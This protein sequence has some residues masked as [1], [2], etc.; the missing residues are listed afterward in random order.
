MDAGKALVVLA[1]QPVLLAVD[2]VFFGI[3]EGEL[4]VF[5]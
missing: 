1:V 4:V 5:F 2:S 3:L